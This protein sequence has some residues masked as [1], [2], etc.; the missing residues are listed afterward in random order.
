MYVLDT[1]RGTM[2]VKCQIVPCHY[3]YYYNDYA[4]AVDDDDD[5]DDDD[6]LKENHV[7]FS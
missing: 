6:D 4:A 5:E 2:S 3:Y 1:V 7:R